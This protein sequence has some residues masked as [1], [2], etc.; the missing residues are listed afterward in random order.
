MIYGNFKELAL[1][2]SKKN[3]EE[4]DAYKKKRKKCY[5]K[6]VKLRKNK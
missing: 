2:I 6:K 5:I 1:K 3:K 4:K